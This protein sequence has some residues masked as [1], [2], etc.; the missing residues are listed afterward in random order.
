MTDNGE[1]S[2]GTKAIASLAKKPSDVTRQG[3]Q[4]L[5][6]VP[7]LPARRKKEYVASVFI[8]PPVYLTY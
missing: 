7:T 5:K 1:P 3:T 6:F 8:A 4:K 2:T